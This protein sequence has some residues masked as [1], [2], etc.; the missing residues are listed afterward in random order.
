MP[1]QPFRT[2][3]F[4]AAMSIIG[5]ALL[6][7]LTVDLY[8][9]TERPAFTLSFNLPNTPPELLERL[10]TAPLENALSTVGG[11]KK[12]SSVSEHGN[13]SI[14][15]LFEKG[16]DLDYKRFEVANLVRRYYP[17]LPAGTSY[18]ILRRGDATDRSETPLL[19]YSVFGPDPA[20]D[21]KNTVERSVSQAL[22]QLPG[23][24]AV[25]VRGAQPWQLAITF[26][27]QKMA[28]LGVSVEKLVGTL[29]QWGT[30]RH[31]GIGERGNG[32]PVFMAMGKQLQQ[33]EE[34]QNMAI[35]SSTGTKV[36]LRDVATVERLPKRPSSFYRVNGQNAVRLL[37]T[38]YKGSN[39]LAVGEALKQRMAQL[40][41]ELPAGYRLRTDYDDTEFVAKELDKIYTR[42]FLS[43]LILILFIL[44]VRRNLRYL[45][46]LLSGIFV[47]LSLIIIC[48][49]AL[50]LNIHLYTLAGLTVSF[51]I[52]LDNALVMLDHFHRERNRKVFLALLAASLTSMAAL[53]MVLLLPE[54]D[55][56][57]LTEF[58]LVVVLGIATS[59]VVALWYTPAA[60]LL[61]MGNKGI[62]KSKKE[63][64]NWL[65]DT[66]KNSV[67]W[68]SAKKKWVIVGVVLLFGTPIFWLPSKVEGWEWY[69]KTL[70]SEWYLENVRP[71]TDKWLGGTLRLFVRDVFEKS[72]YRTNERTR[73]YVNA[74]MPVGHT[75]AQMDAAMQQIERY[76]QGIAGVEQFITQVSS[77][78][79]ARITIQFTEE[80]ENGSLPYQLRARLISRSVDLGGVEWSI[81]GVGQGF[82]NGRNSGIASYRV[83][84]RGHNFRELQR[85]ANV[86]AN[87]LLAHKRIQEV[88]T[89][90]LMGWNQRRGQEFRLTLN[91]E[92]LA[93]SDLS[94]SLLTGSL[95]QQGLAYTPSLYLPIGNETL[96]VRIE[97]SDAEKFDIFALRSRSLESATASRFKTGDF[98]SVELV[99]TAPAIHKED[100]QYIRLVGFEYFGSN[101]FGSRYLNK[102]LKEMEGILPAG[103]SAERKT[104]QWDNEK[105]KRQYGLLF[106]LIAAIYVICAVLFESLKLPFY[107]IVMIPVSFIGVFLIFG[108]FGFYFDQGGYAAFV[109]LGG[110]VVN[111]AIIILN[112]ANNAKTGAWND[113]MLA[114][115]QKK[116]FP[117]LLTILSTV[118]GLL[119]FLMEGQNEVFWFAFAVGTIGGLFFSLFAVFIFLPVLLLKKEVSAM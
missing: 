91:R 89:D 27:P 23:V 56:M 106:L 34:L 94:P 75:L 32:Q 98:A 3:L 66:Y 86:L 101:I 93:L 108:W 54:E 73:L 118:L 112:D 20:E 110:L 14:T 53:L 84:M 103:Y 74:R 55:R 47:N 57:N 111:A 82:N 1:Y 18:P 45:A 46:V 104:W 87:K 25:A 42:A 81:Y 97:S 69:N 38:A 61:W 50:D 99:N 109:M 92:R 2:V 96:P 116:A 52:L 39:R 17:Q 13:G 41:N 95:R 37:V 8:P 12:L 40:K 80:A 114:A 15:M 35:A 71:F 31:L 113:K 11:L 28:A 36:L 100:R 21:I 51:G 22:K 102:V 70:G 115:I 48:L 107:I 60:H 83:E 78:Q 33:L 7:R 58:A 76:L 119:P 77:G 26:D 49:W 10:V 79:R 30:H 16:E 90:E 4:F 24:E 5:W 62:Q 105:T 6:P 9:Q 29:Q 117:I 68:L 72:G 64:P 59:M 44:I 85:Q 65:T 19:I 43:V 88:E 67:L 63:K